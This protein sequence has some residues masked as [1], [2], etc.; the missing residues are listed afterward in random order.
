VRSGAKRL[1]DVVGAATL[2]VLLFPLMLLIA[3][4]VRLTS[5]GPALFRQLRQGY[6]GRPFWFLKFRTM[7][8][9]AEHR[10]RDLEPLNEA[11]G[12]V[13][14][15]MRRD[16]RVTPLGRL[17]RRT[18]L[19]ELPQLVNVIRGEMSLVG[20]RP[21]QMRDSALLEQL[22]PEFYARRLTVLPGL[23]GAWQ[24]GGRSE[25]DTSNMLQL[26]R[27]YVENWSLGRDLV[28]LYRT[29]G[30]VLRGRGAY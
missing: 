12:G 3:L 28:I 8:I 27:D 4:L 14:F 23:T 21:L 29:I 17:L 11:A 18:S 25:T 9:D 26:D 30:A 22:E 1:I 6:G 16:P 5:P 13:L 10:L 20:P 24:V 7:T 19:D 15:K 2:L